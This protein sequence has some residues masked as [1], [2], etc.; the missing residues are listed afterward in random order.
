[1]T[2]AIY[3]CSLREHVGKTILAIGM[4]LHLQEEGKKVAYFKPI[5]IP[6]GA[7]SLKADKDVGFVLN[8]VFKTSLPYDVISPVMIPDCYYVDLIDSSKKEENLS[9]VKQSYDKIT[10][11][12]DY[13]I[14]EGAPSIKKYIRV[15]LDDV[16]VAQALGI[17]ELIFI[18]TE[19]SDK[20]IDN[21]FFTKKYF[22][23][24]EVKIKGVIFNQIDFEYRARIEELRI[25]HI[26]RY[27]IPIIGLIEKILELQSPRVSELQ[28]IIGGELINEPA[29]VNLNE[30]VETYLIAA[31][32]LQAAQKYLRSVKKAAVITGGD[33]TDIALAALNEN[34]SALILTG[35]IQPDAA[36]IYAANEK[37]IPIILSPSDTYTTIRNMERVKPGIQEEEINMVK[38]LV[39]KNLDWDLL[40]GK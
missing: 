4:L 10:R 40:F 30:T 39:K 26:N 25:N 14:I 13:I 12:Y 18:E 23:F 3:L 17:N 16:S 5:G 1:M 33:R 11:D 32:N 36:V 24:R 7:F 8:T 29:R 37:K 28:Y 9:K 22:E 27:N 19:S 38:D 15:G 20:C 2:K 21:L 34:V 6:I 35:Y 31:M